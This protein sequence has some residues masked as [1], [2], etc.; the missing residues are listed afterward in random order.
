MLNPKHHHHH[1]GIG[2]KI[3]STP[4]RQPFSHI[5]ELM[6]ADDWVKSIEKKL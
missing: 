1:Q 5:V 2:L 4:S 6:D 3:F